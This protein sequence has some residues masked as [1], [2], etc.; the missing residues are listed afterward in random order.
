MGGAS[1][2]SFEDVLNQ[3]K[4]NADIAQRNH[5]LV[6]LSPKQ[7]KSFLLPPADEAAE[8]YETDDEPAGRLSDRPP[9]FG[10]YISDAPSMISAQPSS[11]SVGRVSNN[12]RPI[13]R[14][15]KAS[16]QTS[17]VSKNLAPISRSSK[18]VSSRPT[19]RGSSRMPSILRSKKGLGGPPLTRAV[20]T[21]AQRPIFPPLSRSGTEL[22]TPSVL[23]TVKPSHPPVP[24]SRA[25]YMTFVSYGSEDFDEMDASEPP[26]PAVQEPAAFQPPPVNMKTSSP[27]P[28]PRIKTPT[29]AKPSFSNALQQAIANMKDD[30]TDKEEASD[31]G[32]YVSYGEDLNEPQATGTLGQSQNLVGDSGYL[33]QG[34][35]NQLDKFQLPQRGANDVDS[36]HE[37]STWGTSTGSI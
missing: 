10:S 6:E 17:R 37:R 12:L 24:D 5:S 27:V 2:G 11:T 3:T 23:K 9:S 31:T 18:N 15:S 26:P 1:N 19:N 7:Q 25:S 14:I 32:T 4:V 35:Q 16:K 29:K 20:R 30:E 33:L 13:S 34:L 8:G 22:T 28:P 21:S 36:S